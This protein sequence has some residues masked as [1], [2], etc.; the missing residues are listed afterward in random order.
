MLRSVYCP[1]IPQCWCLIFKT[2]ILPRDLRHQPRNTLQVQNPWAS[3]VRAEGRR[4]RSA[5][6]PPLPR[7]RKGG[8]FPLLSLF[9]DFKA[10]LLLLLLFGRATQRRKKKGG[11]F[12][13]STMST[14][15]PG[16]VHD[17]EVG[18]FIATASILW[19]FSSSTINRL[20]LNFPTDLW[21]HVGTAP[22]LKKSPTG[23]YRI[24]R[25]TQIICM[26]K[27]GMSRASH[28][29]CR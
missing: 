10:F 9:E 12:G 2:S 23:I 5:S 7:A 20:F 19:N 1:P 16:L 24:A 18:W 4:S 26:E 28:C 25:I 15:F 14:T 8:T 22:A 29:G 21:R 27:R 3:P 13:E 11:Y 6:F 17:A